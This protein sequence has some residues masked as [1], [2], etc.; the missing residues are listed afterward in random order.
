MSKKEITITPNMA[1]AT[2]KT[3]VTGDVFDEILEIEV[4]QAQAYK[5]LNGTP[6]IAKLYQSGGTELPPDTEIII[7]VSV[8]GKH[9]SKELAY[10]E[11]GPFSDL[12]VSEQVPEDNQGQLK[13][14]FDEQDLQG[15]DGLKF[16]PNMIVTIEI[17]SSAAV[18]WTE[19]SII[20]FKAQ[21]VPVG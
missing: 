2:K 11:Y 13:I 10:L 15:R 21:E 5:I 18:D 3:N 14:E 1:S 20:R 4:P 17:R 8:P 16:Q 12:K 9:K 19:N 6:M 7:G